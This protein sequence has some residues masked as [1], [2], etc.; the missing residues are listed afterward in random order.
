LANRSTPP[1]TLNRKS[2]PHFFDGWHTYI[3]QE[4]KKNLSQSATFERAQLSK[5]INALQRDEGTFFKCPCLPGFERTDFVEEYST[6]R[7][8]ITSSAIEAITKAKLQEVLEELRKGG[9]D[10]VHK[11]LPLPNLEDAEDED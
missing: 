9:M 1:Y 11:Y 4:T 5:E 6:I 7:Y 2:R 8:N 3:Y 10:V